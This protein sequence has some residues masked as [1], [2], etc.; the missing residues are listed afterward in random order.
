MS[1]CL[2]VQPQTWKDSSQGTSNS[3]YSLSSMVFFFFFVLF[4]AHFSNSFFFREEDLEGGRNTPLPLQKSST[5]IHVRQVLPRSEFHTE[6][7]LVLVLWV[8]SSGSLLVLLCHIRLVFGGFRAWGVDPG[9]RWLKSVAGQTSR[10]KKWC[11]CQA[12]PTCMQ[13]CEAR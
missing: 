9:V 12:L 10:G 7:S 11:Q 5:D 1:S 2:F 13:L 3:R 4:K 6:A 8:S